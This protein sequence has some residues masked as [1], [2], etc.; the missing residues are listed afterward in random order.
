MQ[1]LFHI[2]TEDFLATLRALLLELQRLT[3]AALDGG[4]EILARI[5]GT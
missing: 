5:L 1:L 2:V 4:F 3:S